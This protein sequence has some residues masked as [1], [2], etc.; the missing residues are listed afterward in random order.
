MERLWANAGSKLVS[1][2]VVTRPHGDQHAMEVPQMWNAS[3]SN[4]QEQSS[5]PSDCIQEHL[6][7]DNKILGCGWILNGT[8]FK[9]PDELRVT[10][11][12]TRGQKRK[13]DE[14]KQK[15]RVVRAAA[16]VVRASNDNWL[17]LTS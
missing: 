4:P 14:Q 3:L 2:V 1:C 12:L 13:L 10:T 17:L 9:M 6:E 8:S 11:E 7:S 5:H 16:K 15:R